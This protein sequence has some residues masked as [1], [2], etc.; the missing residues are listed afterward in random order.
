MRINRKTHSVRI[1]LIHGFV[2]KKYTRREPANYKGNRMASGSEFGISTVLF[3][4]AVTVSASAPVGFYVAGVAKGDIQ[5]GSPAPTEKIWLKGPSLTLTTQLNS[6]N[7]GETK[8]MTVLSMGS[9]QDASR[10]CRFEPLIRDSFYTIQSRTAVEV[11][12]RNNEPNL[13]PVRFT[14]N[15]T[16]KDLLQG[17]APDNIVVWAEQDAKQQPFQE[18]VSYCEA[19]ILIHG[20]GSKNGGNS[21][22]ATNSILF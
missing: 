3:V 17:G 11:N 10:A 4:S 21:Q 5:L 12:R 7:V 8:L 13:S 20:I 22:P 6:K 18:S 15:E 2:I 14:I 19:G 16:L 9:V 1:G